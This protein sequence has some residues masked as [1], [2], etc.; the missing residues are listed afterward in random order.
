M[1]FIKS[2]A[3]LL[4]PAFVLASPNPN[5]EPSLIASDALKTRMLMERQSLDLGNLTGLLGSLTGSIQA[6]ETL[7]SP[8]S[9]D[10]IEIVVDN[11]ALLLGN[12]TS[13]ELKSVLTAVG[14][15]LSGNLLTQVESLLTPAL[16]TNVTDILGN[17]HDLLTPTFVSQTT[18]LIGDVA[19][20][21]S[22]ISQVISVLLSA[23][24]G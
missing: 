21:V 2:L 13:T 14:G 16:L 1:H 12:G 3:V 8:T 9:L 20:L 15:V 19:P 11:L 18:E 4:L 23:V 6:I 17:A 7:L 5:P 24:L 10:N 22:A